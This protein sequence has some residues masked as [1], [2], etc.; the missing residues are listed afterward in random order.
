MAQA[1]VT[2]TVSLATPA[3]QKLNDSVIRLNRLPKHRA[4]A[5]Q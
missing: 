2:E 3:P 5:Q 1:C 4:G